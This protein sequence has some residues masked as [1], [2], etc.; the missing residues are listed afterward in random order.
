MINLKITFVLDSYAWVPGGGYRVVYEYANNL[1]KRGYDISIIHP[2]QMKNVPY[3][4][5]I[6]NKISRGLGKIRNLMFK[7]SLKWQHVDDSVKLLYVP[8]LLPK[9]IPDADV[10]IATAWSTAEY[11]MDYPPSKGEKFYLIQ[12]YENWAPENR[13]QATWK[14]SMYKVVIAKWLYNKGL[15]LGVDPSSMVYIPNGLDLNKFKLI[16]NIEGRKKRVVMLYHDLKWK[17]SNDGIEALKIAKEQIPNLE[18]VLFGTGPKPEFLPSWIE[19]FQNPSQNKLVEEIYNNSSIYLCPSWKEGWHLPP[20]EAMAC[21][22]AVI[23]TD[24]GGVK[25]YAIHEKTALLS[26]P[27]NPELLS[28]N[29][30][31]VLNDD[32]LRIR[33]ANAGY[34]NIQRF[35]WEKATDKLEKA[36]NDKIRH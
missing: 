14:F 20:A 2:R 15:D 11:L 18:A 34:S 28:K 33:L 8:E 27:K 6:K 23:S 22:C 16:N 19:Y 26:P 13:L 21:G 12:H 4:K 5:G 24:I 36:I 9:Y 31:K 32:K 7:P 30:L 10:I 1:V 35:T 29:L 17:G 3:P 25:D